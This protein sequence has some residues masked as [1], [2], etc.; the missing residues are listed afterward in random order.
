MNRTLTY[1]GA[2]VPPLTAED[3]LPAESDS[4]P[5]LAPCIGVSVSLNFPG[6]T[7]S[8]REAMRQLIRNSLQTLVE[9]GARPVLLD[10]SAESLPDLGAV[11]RL[12]GLLV[13]GGGDIHPDFALHSLGSTSDF[14]S[15]SNTFGVDRRADEH[16]LEVIRC[17]LVQESPVLA[18]CR[19]HQLLNV[20]FGGTI[21][22]DIGIDGTHRGLNDDA[23]FVDEMI[24]LD[25]DSQVCMLLGRK[26]LYVRG[27]HHQAVDL[28]APELRVTARAQDGTVEGLEHVESARIL[29][30]QWHPEESNASRSD[31]KALLTG[32]F[33]DAHS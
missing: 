8:S 24:N 14:R 10:A 5:A 7:F 25:E 3:V 9:V 31:F 22:P 20:A 19:G 2:A 13:L 26:T 11:R 29:G 18:I 17:V 12:E 4:L 16:S 6:L 1:E 32:F 33:L 15:V 27:A 30:V 23:V 21:I 28:V